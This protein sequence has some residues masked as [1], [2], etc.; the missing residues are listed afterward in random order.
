MGTALCLLSA[1]GFGVMAVFGKLSYDAGASVDMVLLARFGIAGAVLLAVA[2]ARHAFRGL[3]VR[4]VVTGLAMG[5]IGYALQAGFY[6]AA[7]TRVDASLVALILY[8]YP[9]LVMA[10]AIALRRERASVRRCVALVVALTGIVLVLAGASAGQID[11][12]GALLALG[13]ALTYT[14]YILVGDRLTADVPALPLSAL[15]C[16]GAFGTFLIIGTT[17][18]TVDLAIAPVG[19]LWLTAIALISTVAAVLCFFAGLARV[20]PSKAAI[21]SI[22]EPVVTVGSAALVFGESMGPAQWCGG[23][24]VLGAVVIVQWKRRSRPVATDPVTTA[25]GPAAIPARCAAAE[26]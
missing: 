15:V 13:S 3:T 18:H 10:G 24:L 5:A 4:P 1:V 22:L 9:V 26:G 2:A 8:V 14:V 11:A 6:F 21:L 25:N 23:L 17:G 20:G 12:L 7:L 16:C 19:W